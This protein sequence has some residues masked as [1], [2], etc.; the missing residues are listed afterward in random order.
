MQ[1]EDV[2]TILEASRNY[3]QPDALG[4]DYQQVAKFLRRKRTD[5]TLERYLREFDVLPRKAEANVVMGGAFLAGFV[6][7]LEKQSTAPSKTE[8]SLLFAGVQ[9]SVESPITAKQMRRL[10]DPCVGPA[11]HD[12]SA[13]T[14]MDAKSDEAG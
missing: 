8:K 3:L 2:E 12:A 7:I 14:E 9:G 10:F 11:R 4:H 6:S 13:A 5:Q 1:R